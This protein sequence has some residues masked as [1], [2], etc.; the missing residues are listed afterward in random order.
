M[1]LSTEVGACGK[2]PPPR[3]TWR[4]AQHP[5]VCLLH[6]FTRSSFSCKGSHVN[7]TKYLA[8]RATNITTLSAYPL[9]VNAKFDCLLQMEQENQQLKM[10]NL[11]QTEQ[12]MLLKDKLQGEGRWNWSRH[13]DIVK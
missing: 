9:K 7:D 6:L 11:K 3:D 12:I 5:A 4:D 1:S 2:I 8:G 13:N 10:A